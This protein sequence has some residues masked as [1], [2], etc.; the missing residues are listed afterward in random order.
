MYLPDLFSGENTPKSF[1]LVLFD[2]VKSADP[3]KVSVKIEFIISR[4][5]SDD[6]LVARDGC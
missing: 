3:P 4:V 2:P 5:N 6:F 1:V